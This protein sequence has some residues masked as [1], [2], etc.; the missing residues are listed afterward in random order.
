MGYVSD[1]MVRALAA[2]MDFCYIVCQSSLDEFDLAALDKA[3]HCFE[4]ECTIFETEDIHPNGISISRIH[5]LQHYC[6][7]IQLFGAPNGISTS[8]VE[9]KHIQVVKR[10]YRRSNKTGELGQILLTNQQQD[11]LAQFQAECFAKG[12]GIEFITSPCNLLLVC[13]RTFGKAIGFRRQCSHQY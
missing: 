10:P 6:E 12:L 2:F 4:T 11:K 7:A 3:L 13:F 9:S 1:Q 8:I 5:A